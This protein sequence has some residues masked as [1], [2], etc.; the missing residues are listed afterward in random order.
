GTE[1]QPYL[2]Q[3]NDYCYYNGMCN[4][5][6]TSCACTYSG[7]YC[8]PAGTVKDGVCYYGTRDCN[9]NGCTLDKEEM[10]CRNVCDATLGPIDTTGPV[11]PFDSITIKPNPAGPQC[12]GA[13][14]INATAV[15]NCTY[16]HDAEFYVYKEYQ[17]ATCMPDGTQQAWGKMQAV[18]GNYDD[19]LIEEVS[20]T[21][22]VGGFY[23]SGNYKLCVKAQNMDGANSSCTCVRL[24]ID[25]MHPNL[26]DGTAGILNYHWVDSKGYWVCADDFVYK[27]YFCD[28]NSQ[29]CIAGAEY[30]IV[31]PMSFNQPAG[32]GIPMLPSDGQF[33]E[34][35]TT[36]E[37]ANATIINTDYSEGSHAIKSEAIDCACN[38][39]KLLNQQP[40]Y[41]VI[42]RTPP[43]SSKTVGEPKF[44]CN[45]LG[46]QN[47]A[48]ACWHI[49]PSTLITLSAQDVDNSWDGN[50]SDAV[51]IYYRYRWKHNYADP[52]GAW[53][54]WFEYA[55]PFQFTEDS[56]HELEYYAVD[57]CGNEETHHFEIDIVDSKPPVTTK[58]IGNPKVECN[59]TDKAMY[60]MN[61][62]WYMTDE[63]PIT[64][65]CVDQEPHPIDTVTLYYTIEWKQ[66]WGDSWQVIANGSKPGTYSFYYEDFQN[67]ESYH[68]LTWY[69]K[70]A[71]NNTESTHVE[72]DIVDSTP[73]VT[74][75]TII[76]P[77][78]YNS[79][80]NKT[81]IDGVTE[82]E[83]N[84]TD[85]QPHP[86]N[87]VTIYYRYRVDDGAWPVDFTVYTGRF[88]FPEESKH[89]LEYYCKDALNNTEQHHFEIDYVDK[90][91]PVTEITFCFP[92]SFCGHYN[93]GTAEW[94]NSSTP[95]I[96]TAS[97]GNSAH[98]SGVNKT[99][100]RNTLVADEYCLSEQACAGANG[101]G[102]WNEYT[103]PFYKQEES[104]HLIE[105]YSVD[106]VNKTEGV[107]NKC[108]FVDN[109]PPIS[110]KQVGNPKVE[111]SESEKTY[112]GINDCWYM[113]KDTPINI[114]CTDQ[115]PH[116]VGETYIVWQVEWKHYW[117]D[118]EWTFE[119]GGSY[120]GGINITYGQLEAAN[121]GRIDSYHKLTW[122]CKDRVGN[123]GEEH[124][125][126]DVV[127]SQ[128][129]S[130]MK[131]VGEPKV[132]YI[133][134][135]LQYSDKYDVE[136]NAWYVNQSTLITLNCTDGQ[137]HPVGG[138]EIYYKY[139][140][141]GQLV[142]DWML[143]TAPFHYNED[144]YHELYY[145]CRDRLNNTGPIH[146]EYDVVDSLPPTISKTITGPQQDAPDPY[147][148]FLSSLSNITINC[149]DQLP[150]PVGGEMLHWEMY[151][152]NESGDNWQLIG[153]GTEQGYKKFTNLDDSYH[154]F[155][156]WCEDALG[157]TGANET[158]LDI[159]D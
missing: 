40:I 73:P 103:A 99:Y 23:D 8:P 100:W 71:L 92:H 147:H 30:F 88:T 46:D 34:P 144:S 7:E 128:A 122:Y 107:K 62:C 66:N 136:D 31:P 102:A 113:T 28:Q 29:S 108:V 155:V 24:E 59:A 10:T 140:N 6:P 105:F 83:L 75:K 15:E 70:D 72:L 81:Y 98:S 11:V 159:V 127:D 4:T 111:C 55:T 89:E 43:A 116:P 33:G 57:R 134:D 2:N 12:P 64:L 79:T 67:Y 48:E 78:Y 84:C 14:L 32:E 36:C 16:I 54:D 41:V 125:E 63:T 138:E 86:V 119:L 117:N 95:V 69:C 145:Y 3:Q 52:W 146:A 151:W 97:D 58:T 22:N 154:N 148:K 50:Y 47:E 51:K 158:E 101:S 25:N 94:I 156:Y 45:Y 42:D 142:Q 39:G 153:S 124:V 74:T 65:Q 56:I 110:N 129:P 87:N 17:T 143:Y 112:Y 1:C 20:G 118:S 85:P 121:P 90:T 109:T 21:V 104:C 139:Y 131:T 93:N 26:M 123:V 76:G 18:D 96:L 68:K 115:L 82:I 5:D 80:T 60:G 157:N 149:T 137:P 130:V 114:T 37:W 61:D 77:Q 19:E 53:S 120:P 132:P 27:G 44:Q 106:N 126:L 141:D 152:K 133:L 135:S 9:E 150:H 35:E 49:K 91:P 38:W 13:T